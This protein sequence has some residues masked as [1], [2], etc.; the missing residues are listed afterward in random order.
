MDLRKILARKR[1]QLENLEA[2]LGVLRDEVATLDRALV[3]AS[4]EEESDASSG[5]TERDSPIEGA[6]I[7]DRRIDPP[8]PPPAT[9]GRPTGKLIALIREIV[10]ELPEPFSTAEVR[11]EIKRR[12]PELFEATHYS[13]ISGTM[14]R[15]AK[16]RQLV[17]IEKGGPGKEATYRRPQPGDQLSLEPRSEHGADD[18]TTPE[19]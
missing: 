19:G 1:H 13:S 5:R 15:M 18:V 14:R 16:V 10:R 12:D 11:E 8:P 3:I 17:P 9:D 6:S 7:V 4:R 2:Q